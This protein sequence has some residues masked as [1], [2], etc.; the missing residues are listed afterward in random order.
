MISCTHN[1]QKFAIFINSY[2]FIFS[3]IIVLMFLDDIIPKVGCLPPIF[4]SATNIT[5]T[6]IF[7]NQTAKQYLMGPFYESIVGYFYTFR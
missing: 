4:S 6:V 1:Y 5:C 2:N 7:K 3:Y